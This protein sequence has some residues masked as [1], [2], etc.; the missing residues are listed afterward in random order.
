MDPA[1]GTSKTRT[2]VVLHALAFVAGFT[3]VFVS[4]GASA[5]AVRQLLAEH[6][7]L[8]MR[9]AGGIVVL[10]GLS[11]PGDASPLLARREQIARW[12]DERT[13]DGETRGPGQARARGRFRSRLGHTDAIY[14]PIMSRIID[15]IPSV[16][17][18]LTS[19]A[20]ARMTWANASSDDVSVT[21]TPC[22]VRLSARR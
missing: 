21:E 17:K 13:D 2:N 7:Q 5:S 22:G 16:T 12:H 1:N 10:L 3:I 6:K 11:E 15:R 9:V 4:L 8:L 18:P 20:C 14:E 19:R